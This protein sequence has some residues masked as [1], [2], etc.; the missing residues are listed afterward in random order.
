MHLS[1]EDLSCYVPDMLLEQLVGE[2]A[3]VS[4]PA[5]SLQA[6]ALFADISGFTALTE[7]LAADGAVGVE[8][9]SH[10]LNAHMSRLIDIV[11]RHGG[12]IVRFEGDGLLALWPDSAQAGLAG[13]VRRAAA[14]GLH[15]QRE[16]HHR[17]AEGVRLTLRVGVGCGAVFTAAIESVGGRCEFLAVGE[18]VTQ[19]GAAERQAAPGQVRLSSEAWALV[20]AEGVGQTLAPSDF[21]SA[22]S[23]RPARPPAPPT[24]VLARYVPRPVMAR[25]AVGQT[26]W[27]AELRQISVVFVRFDG[28]D[29]RAELDGGGKTF[30]LLHETLG[31]FEGTVVH[32]GLDAGGPAALCA[33]GLPPWAHED[34]ALRAVSAAAAL[35]SR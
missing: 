13:A 33:F 11:A 9:I 22:L 3:G 28:L 19:S 32:T 20:R 34:D 25:L 24:D 14:C 8:E 17:G 29:V 35:R 1:A 12:D 27:I 5:Q 6:A 4:L 10:I 30:Q 31:Q 2:M 7:K 21:P 15:I 23:P 18:A 26:A 16:L